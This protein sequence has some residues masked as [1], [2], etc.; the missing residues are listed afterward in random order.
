MAT[1]EDN[2]LAIDISDGRTVIGPAPAERDAAH[3]WYRA[4]EAVHDAREVITPQRCAIQPEPPGIDPIRRRVEGPS[5]D[6]G[7]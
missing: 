4:N 7:F 1:S 6:I 3:A 5:L 2:K